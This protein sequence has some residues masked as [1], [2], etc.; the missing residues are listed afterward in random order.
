MARMVEQKPPPPWSWE[1]PPEEDPLVRARQAIAALRAI[2]FDAPPPPSHD[3][4]I[5]RLARRLERLLG[6]S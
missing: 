1:L 6:I 5:V 4:P 3:G 2:D